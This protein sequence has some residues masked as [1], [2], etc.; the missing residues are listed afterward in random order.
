MKQLLRHADFKV[1][2]ISMVMFVGALGLTVAAFAQNKA[3]GQ[4]ETLATQSVVRD[5]LQA[6]KSGDLQRAYSHA[7]PNIT[8]HFPTVELF[9]TMVKRGYGA[10]FKAD[11]FVFGRNT[12]YNNEVYQ[13][14]LITDSSGKQ[15]QAVYTLKQQTDGSWKITGVK[16]EP[17]KGLST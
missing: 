7:A 17:H 2:A 15:W 1:L 16:M 5:Q 11:G 13:E 4:A 8:A 10:I 3:V 14:V 6:F 9:S 12:A